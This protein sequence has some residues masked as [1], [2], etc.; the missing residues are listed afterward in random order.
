MDYR[1]LGQSGMAVSQLALGTMYFGNETAEKEAF[2]ILD[3]F[4]EKGGTLIDTSDVYVGGAAEKIVGHWMASRPK[5]VTDHV[6]LATKGRYPTGE[7][8]NAQGL[9][10]R[11]LHRALNASLERLKVDTIDL[12]Q[13][14]GTDP[15]T[16]MEETLTFLDDAVRA[17]KI[18]YVGLSNFNGWEI[19]RMVSTAQ[20]MGLTVPVSHQPQY[21]LLSREIEWEIIPASMHNG[22]GLLPWSPLAGG[23]LTGKYERNGIPDANT[24]AGSDNPLYQWSSAEF[25]SSD[26]AWRVIG[27]VREAATQLGATPSQVAL[28]WLIDRPSVTAPI[29]GARTLAHLEDNLGAVDLDLGDE[30]TERLE[31]LS[32]PVPENCYPYGD[33]GDAMRTRFVGKAEHAVGRVVGG[34]S[35]APL[36]GKPK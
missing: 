5:E 8:V 6:V 3:A 2:T 29:C 10:R 14:H 28:R 27:A 15:L 30:I 31:T 12:Y 20:A 33:F 34:G 26:R 35:D 9:S 17:G 23:M 21:N 7:D 36:S 19:Q 24:R 25:V 16:S 22:L 1:L 32:R 18:H 13:L 11:H 4:M